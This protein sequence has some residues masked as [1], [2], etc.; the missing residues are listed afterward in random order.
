MKL[1][2]YDGNI[3]VISGSFFLLINADHTAELLINYNPLDGIVDCV[4]Y[5]NNEQHD[6]AICHAGYLLKSQILTKIRDFSND[7]DRVINDFL[8]W[9]EKYAG[10]V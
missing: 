5:T 8:K 7:N 3:E 6:Y 9:V 10:M 2:E 1:Y 4:T